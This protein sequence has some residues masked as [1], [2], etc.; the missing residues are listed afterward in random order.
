MQN[1]PIKADHLHEQVVLAHSNQD[2]LLSMN[3]TDMF[4]RVM[5]DVWGEPIERIL[6][7]G[8]HDDSPDSF[9][10]QAISRRI[11]LAVAEKLKER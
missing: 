3:Q 7:S 2:E 6:I 9:E 10:M 5:N 11:I 1:T 8:K 4:Q